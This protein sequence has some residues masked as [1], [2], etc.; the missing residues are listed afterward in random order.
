M[1]NNV[2]GHQQMIGDGPGKSRD[3]PGTNVMI[4]VAEGKTSRTVVSHST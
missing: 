1:H 3:S 4:T 2:L